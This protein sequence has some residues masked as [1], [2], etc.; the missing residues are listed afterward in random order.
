MH[1]G[2]GDGLG[3]G[4]TPVALGSALTP[5]GW[6]ASPFGVGLGGP[7]GGAATA[8]VFHL[9]V[10]AKVQAH[11]PPVVNSTN[12]MPVPLFSPASSAV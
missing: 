8:S 10:S 11:R 3:V 1:A 12:P 4:V 5:V 6:L 7:P 2:C 9:G